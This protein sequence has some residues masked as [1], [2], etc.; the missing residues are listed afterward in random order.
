MKQCHNSRAR[1]LSDWNRV[2][3]KL[4]PL[5]LESSYDRAVLGS[6]VTLIRGRR[7]NDLRAAVQVSLRV[8]FRFVSYALFAQSPGPIPKVD[9][10]V[11]DV[12]ESATRRRPRS[13]EGASIRNRAANLPEQSWF[14]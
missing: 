5:P 6:A 1:T 3:S 10:E 9:H 12:L 13:T 4:R 11:Q 2:A 14:S 8:L 7:C